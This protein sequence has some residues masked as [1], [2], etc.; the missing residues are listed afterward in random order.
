MTR[1]VAT[2][3]QRNLVEKAGTTCVQAY[4]AEG[5]KR[6]QGAMMHIMVRFYTIFLL[7]D[8]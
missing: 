8:V 5:V 4:M 3:I 2:T 1:T 6:L 7:V